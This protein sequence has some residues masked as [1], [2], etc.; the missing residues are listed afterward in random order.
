MQRSRVLKREA[1]EVTF[2]L[3]SLVL[4]LLTACHSGLDET[5]SVSSSDTRKQLEDVCKSV[6]DFFTHVFG[7]GG[8]GGSEK[9]YEEELK[10]R[11]LNRAYKSCT[12]TKIKI[13]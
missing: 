6:P 3:V 2:E 7:S 4:N 10:V 9:K 8:F 13:R 11:A 5:L 1:V 12:I